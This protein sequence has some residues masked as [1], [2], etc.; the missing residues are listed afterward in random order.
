MWFW[1][2]PTGM[3]VSGVA[4]YFMKLN[5]PKIWLDEIINSEERNQFCPE[6]TLYQMETVTM[7]SKETFSF[8]GD[9][10]MTVWAGSKNGQRFSLAYTEVLEF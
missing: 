9:L 6:K 4:M 10:L 2:V 1:A 3:I 8:S 7:V 5:N